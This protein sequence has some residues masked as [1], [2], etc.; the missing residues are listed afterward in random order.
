[1]RYGGID[2]NGVLYNKVGA[3]TQAELEEKERDITTFRMASL[4]INA[5]K[6]NFD[7]VHLK[8]IHRY[9]F[10]PIYSW[11]GEINVHHSFRERNGRT[12]RVFIS[13]LA[14][15]AGYKLNLNDIS[16]EEMISASKVV[17]ERLDY[18]P[19]EKIL[20]QSISP[21]KSE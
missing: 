21:I 20:I 7:L 10:S 14:Q 4:Q 1:M 3:K 19:L 9:I 5:I 13:Q 15:Q 12:Q 18:P 2:Q 6:G 11:A 8:A 17:L 16:Q